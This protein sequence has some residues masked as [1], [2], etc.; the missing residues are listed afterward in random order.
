[1]PE[2][3]RQKI[4]NKRRRT[5]TDANKADALV[6]PSGEQADTAGHKTDKREL[7]E[8]T[9]NGLAWKDGTPLRANPPREGIELWAIKVGYAP[10]LVERRVNRTISCSRLSD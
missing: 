8:W 7:A 3:R 6:A 1:M 4:K 10:G 9:I 5:K 2:T